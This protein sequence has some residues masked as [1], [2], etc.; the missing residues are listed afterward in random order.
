MRASISSWTVLG[1]STRVGVTDQ[2]P[3]S[4][5]LDDDAFVDEGQRDLLRERG[6]AIS[7]RRELCGHQR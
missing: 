1:I 5:G 2:R 7:A 4:L 3:L 6:I